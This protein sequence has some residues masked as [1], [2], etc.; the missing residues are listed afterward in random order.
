MKIA[1]CGPPHSGK[2][3]LRDRLI[4]AV[5]DQDPTRYLFP[6]TAN[7]D[8]EGSWFQKAYNNDPDIA[9][10]L[11]I[12]AKQVWTPDK[13][14]LYAGWVRNCTA[15]LTLI[16]LGGVID[17]MNRQI[18]ALATHAILLAPAD[19]QFPPWRDFCR[20]CGI[21]ILAELRSDYHAPADTILSTSTPFRARIHHLERGDLA[22]PRPA[23]DALAAAIINWRQR[24]LNSNP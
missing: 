3:V 6:L 2:S 10:A 13:A 24:P 14:T 22:S 19:A 8:G 23:I 5:K 18:C 17:A 1:L 20:D 4:K 7:P 15:P 16:D 12:R 11:K 9:I 21:E